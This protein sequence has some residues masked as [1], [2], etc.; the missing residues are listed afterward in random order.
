MLPSVASPPGCVKRC[1][2]NRLGSR[3]QDEVPDGSPARVAFVAYAGRWLREGGNSDSPILVSHRDLLIEDLA[4]LHI[5][6]NAARSC[7]HRMRRE[8]SAT[9]DGAVWGFPRYHAHIDPG[10][11]H[12]PPV[13][14]KHPSPA[15]TAYDARA[16][17]LADAY[18][19]LTFEQVHE[20][21]LDLLPKAPARI[22][23]VGAGSGRDAAWLA[24]RGHEVI[25]IEP[26]SGMRHEARERHPD[27]RIR[28]LED[29]L[30]ALPEA[31]RLG[32]E[33]DFIFASAVWMHVRPED[34][35]RAF[36]KLVTL[37]AQRT[38]RHLAAIGN[39]GPGSRHVPRLLRR[40]RAPRS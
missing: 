9:A 7:A 35:Q 32:L 5:L 29:S 22:L 33:F 14:A 1:M 36:R 8:V 15:I 20:P 38:D 25:A 3:Y 26:S 12:E 16:R 13:A 17:E 2:G 28:W 34:R 39:A 24:Y 40:S 21:I 19:T 30:P 10:R 37:L 4:V 18:E 11:R 31:H 27:P 6:R 23:D